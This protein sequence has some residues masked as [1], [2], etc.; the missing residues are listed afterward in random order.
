MDGLTLGEI[1][2]EGDWLGETLGLMLGDTEG[3]IEGETDAE[4]DWE[5][6]TEGDAEFTSI[7]L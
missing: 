1:E 4:G 3:L 2:A 5:G 6:L 7:P